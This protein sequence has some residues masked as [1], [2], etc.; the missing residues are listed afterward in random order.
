MAR[1]IELAHGI[2]RRRFAQHRGIETPRPLRADRDATRTHRGAGG[3]FRAAAQLVEPGSRAPWFPERTNP[4]H[5]HNPEPAH[6]PDPES[7]RRPV[8]AGA[9]PRTGGPA[10]IAA[11]WANALPL[12]T[13]VITTGFPVDG[14]ADSREPG[15]LRLRYATPGYFET[16]RIPMAKGRAFLEADRDGPP[17]AIVSEPLP[18]SCFPGRVRFGHTIKPL[19]GPWHEV[20]GVVKDGTADRRETANRRFT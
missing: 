18:A 11:S 1:R 16:F 7:D 8:R 2:H 9:G 3:Q 12:G 6:Y 4:H 14:A 5:G 10:T 19:S 17:T 15:L 13:Y 20:V